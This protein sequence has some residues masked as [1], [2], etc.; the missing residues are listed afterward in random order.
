MDIASILG[1]VICF[2]L[3]IFGMVFGKSFQ[4]VM[5]FV[6]MPSIIITIGGTFA[7]ML[8][9]AQDI[10]GFVKSLTSIGLIMKTTPSNEEETIKSIIDLSNVARKEGLLAL[11]EAAGSIDDDFLKKGV[12][13]I[14]DG[15]DPELVRSIL[16]TDLGCIDSRHGKIIGFWDGMAAM[17]P[18]W[19]MIGTLIG[20]VNMLK[21]LS[22]MASVGPNMSVALVTTFYGSLIANWICTPTANKLKAK[23]E[24]EIMIKEVMVEGLLSIQA[25]ENPRVIEEKLK[26]FLAPAARGNI[27]EGSEGGE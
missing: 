12:L 26:S 1:I 21:D 25:G 13:L 10:G 11:E 3:I 7:C 9:Q 19:G 22:D 4:A 27:G 23:N 2:G 18:A 24:A 6:D 15:T 5:N 8:T 14:V 16:E 20:L 17:G